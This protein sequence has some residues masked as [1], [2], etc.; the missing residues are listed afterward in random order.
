MSTSTSSEWKS[1][2]DPKSGRIYYY[3]INTRVTTWDKPLELA[4]D[5]E[6]QEMLCKKAETLKFFADMEANIRSKISRGKSS[7]DHTV[8]DDSHSQANKP[9][10]IY[11]NKTEHLRKTSGL[12][13]IR[14]I[15]TIDDDAIEMKKYGAGYEEGGS[16]SRRCVPQST[17]NHYNLQSVPMRTTKNG[18]K[19]RNS[20]GT[21]YVGTTI[22]EQD[23]DATIHCVAVVIRAHMIEASCNSNKS[24]SDYAVFNDKATE[25]GE[26]VQ[27]SSDHKP[28]HHIRRC[29]ADYGSK[30]G[31]T[32]QNNIFTFANS[33]LPN[34]PDL[35]VIRNFFSS[36]Y[37]RTKMES[38]CII[39]A[40][41]YLERLV[42]ETKGRLSICNSNWKSIVFAC[43][44]MASKVWD[45]LSMWNVDF[46]HLMPSFNLRRVNEL[47]LAMLAALK[48][49]V[50]VTAGE[51]AKYY[52]HLRSMMAR[53]GYHVNEASQLS[54]LDMAGAMKLHLSTEEYQVREMAAMSK[55][56][57][58]ATAMERY[59]S[60]DFEANSEHRVLVGLEQLIHGE[61]T[62][63]DGL[64]V[65]KD[66]GTGHLV[67]KRII[68]E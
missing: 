38:E 50:K 7:V 53:L 30:L 20:T 10:Q 31:E 63:A 4:N 37:N 13:F 5:T 58:G 34:V 29:D 23:N 41:V 47:E 33:K 60:C 9:T 26:G 16:I 15:S 12:T 52:F 44:I 17:S 45:D 8:N 48:Y 49:V 62:T 68:E 64:K 35:E 43:L 18:L 54:P 67:L 66:S 32:I 27:N 24:I 39:I 40:L 14:T 19:R 3:N 28:H 11:V 46:S 65:T 61:H 56:H 36:I 42:K 1:A 59:K 21:L 6:K 25:G 55:R 51:Y 57:R 2:R 22:S